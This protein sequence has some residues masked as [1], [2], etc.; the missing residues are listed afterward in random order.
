[1]GNCL[2]GLN[3]ICDKGMTTGPFFRS[4]IDDIRIYNRTVKP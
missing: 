4:L 3:I 2:G 1:L